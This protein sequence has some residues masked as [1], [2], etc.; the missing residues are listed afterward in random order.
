MKRNTSTCFTHTHTKLLW[1][2]FGS[3]NFEYIDFEYRIRWQIITIYLTKQTNKYIAKFD[4]ISRFTRFWVHQYTAN[5]T[6]FHLIIAGWNAQK[7]GKTEKKKKICNL[8]GAHDKLM[9]QNKRQND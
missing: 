4:N 8:H 9:G 7:D 5:T 1:S 6:S 2:E 3:W